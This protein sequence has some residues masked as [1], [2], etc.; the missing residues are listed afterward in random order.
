MQGNV[1]E[2][3]TPTA[4]RRPLPRAAVDRA[5]LHKSAKS[6]CFISIVVEISKYHMNVLFRALDDP[7][8]RRILDLLGARDHTAGELADAFTLGKPTVSH[9]LALLRQAGLVSA[10]KEGQSIR[11]RLEATVLDECL[12]W[13]MTLIERGQRPRSKPTDPHPDEN[14]P[15][16]APGT[17]PASH[18][19]PA[20]RPR[21][22]MV[23]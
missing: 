16:P 5:E 4:N 17:A 1:A 6:S 15:L 21:R 13:F 12:S 20:L 14:T 18:P 2:R 10:H 8:R 11:Y 23:G 7:T 19:G 22:R 3:T 9:H